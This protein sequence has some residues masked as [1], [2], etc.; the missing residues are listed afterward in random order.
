MKRLDLIILLSCSTLLS[1]SSLVPYAHKN[2]HIGQPAYCSLG[3]PIISRYRG[4]RVGKDSSQFRGS[5]SE[6]IYSGASG[7]VVH[8]TYIQY[9]TDKDGAVIRPPTSIPVQYDMAKSRHVA[10]RGYIIDLLGETPTQLH[11]TV[12]YDGV[13]TDFHMM[14]PGDTATVH[15]LPLSQRKHVRMF[16]RAEESY[17]VYVLAE[18]RE[19]YYVSQTLIP[20]SPPLMIFKHFVR[21]I[22]EIK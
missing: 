9:E 22:D 15:L 19:W 13:P 17:D 21:T 2:Y 20:E 11:Y 18:T 7:T 1:C 16:T 4:W 3:E 8:M 6:L 5:S 10:F 14:F 12:M